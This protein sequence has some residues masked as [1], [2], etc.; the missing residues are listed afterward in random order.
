MDRTIIIKELAVDLE[1]QFEC[2]GEKTEK[3]TPFSVP[4]E[5]KLENDKK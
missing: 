2:L 1:G 4:I 3:H 5:E